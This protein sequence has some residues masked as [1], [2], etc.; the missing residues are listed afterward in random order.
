VGTP[1]RIYE[2]MELRL[3]QSDAHW[4]LGARSVGTG[5]VI[6]PFV[7]PLAG[8]DGLRLEYLDRFG[9]PTSTPGAVRSVVIKVRG[10]TEH[11]LTRADGQL[12]EEQLTSQV[13]LRNGVERGP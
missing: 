12:L 3:Y 4:W 11:S 1:V 8:T 2:T 7:G 5:E 13:T 10:T 6:Q 9:A